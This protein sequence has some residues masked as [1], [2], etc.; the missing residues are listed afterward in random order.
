MTQANRR[1][2]LIGSLLQ[3]PPDLP[4]LIFPWLY[5]QT[6]LLLS[7]L[8]RSLK[9]MSQWT[10]TTA[11]MKMT[12]TGS[13]VTRVQIKGRPEVRHLLLSQRKLHLSSVIA[14]SQVFQM[15]QSSASLVPPTATT[16][17][18][19]QRQ[20]ASFASKATSLTHVHLDRDV[21]SA[22]SL[23][24]LKPHAKRNSQWLQAKA[25]WNV[26]FARPRI[27]RRS[28]APKSG[29]PIDHR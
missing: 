21:Q 28:N 9:R 3:H 26:P 13:P 25:L 29:K 15:M 23:A 18:I 19:V 22:S 5:P 20:P 11:T 1:A 12:R 27:T 8:P 10:R 2:L 17:Q 16:L 4:F 24:I 14:I 6:L 7:N